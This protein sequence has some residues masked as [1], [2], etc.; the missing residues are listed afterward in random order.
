MKA[1]G[2]TGG[3]FVGK[4]PAALAPT[5]ANVSKSI[6][7]FLDVHRIYNDRL[8]SGRVEVVRKYT[9]K[10]TGRLKEFTNWVMLAKKGTPDRFF[11][12]GGKIF[13]V[14]VKKWNGKLSEDQMIRHGE[15]RRAGC[16]VIVAHSL[17][18]F[19]QQFNELF[20]VNKNG[21]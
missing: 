9:D 2:L 21:G 4:K 3:L 14:E 17:D 8:N 20:S 12:V 16:T 13:F 1:R 19:I 10:R 6:Q 5:E 7:D 15:L 11:I 18:S